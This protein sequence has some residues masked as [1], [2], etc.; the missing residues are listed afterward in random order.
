MRSVV[1]ARV[2]LL[3]PSPTQ[4]GAS[5]QPPVVEWTRTLDGTVQSHGSATGRGGGR[6]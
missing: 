4:E 6:Y 3:R 2:A 1:Q 5:R